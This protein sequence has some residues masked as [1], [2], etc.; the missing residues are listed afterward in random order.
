[1]G[2]KDEVQHDPTAMIRSVVL[3]RQVESPIWVA[4]SLTASGG[5]DPLPYLARAAE[6]S[7]E[8]VITIQFN[9]RPNERSRICRKA[10]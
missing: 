7:P 4:N 1:M 3:G 9:L 10:W 6:S 8:S 5:S 2:P